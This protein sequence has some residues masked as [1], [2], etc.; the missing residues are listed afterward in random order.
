ML[1]TLTRENIITTTNSALASGQ[2]YPSWGNLG[3]AY[4]TNPYTDT[5]PTTYLRILAAKNSISLGSTPTASRFKGALT[6]QLYFPADYASSTV[7]YAIPPQNSNPAQSLFTA[8][9]NHYL[10]G[11]NALFARIFPANESPTVYELSSTGDATNLT[12]QFISADVG[13]PSPITLNLAG[14]NGLTT[15]QLLSGSQWPFFPTDTNASYTN[16]LSKLVSALFTVGQFPFTASTTSV[17]S[18]F[19]NNNDGYATLSYFSNPPGYSN[20]PWFNLY[21]QLLHQKMI[22]QGDVPSNSSLG[23][24]YAYDFDDLLIGAPSADAL[25]VGHHALPYD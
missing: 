12:L 4:Y 10:N 9:Y 6:P 23:L 20:G 21:D 18:P 22:S 16:E 11:A 7:H 5:V 24:G 15:E 19:V 3:I 14:V 13:S 17:G 8:A 25:T 2:S 1:A